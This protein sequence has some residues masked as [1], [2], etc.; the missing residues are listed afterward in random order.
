[1]APRYVSNKDES[2]PLF[3]NKLLDKFTYMH[4]STPVV[5]YLPVVAY[6]LY[7]AIVNPALSG[8]GI[9]LLFLGGMFAWSL[10]EYLFHRYVFHYETKSDFGRYLHFLMHGIH[11]DYPNDSRRLVMAPAVSIPLALFFYG[12]FW[13]TLGPTVMLAFFS[14]FVFGYL[15]YDMIHYAT[16]HAPMKG[17]IG[18]WLKH[19][20]VRHHYQD[21]TLG[22]GV[23]SPLWDLIFRTMFPKKEPASSPTE[24]H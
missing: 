7:R 12:L 8:T 2:I 19:H 14:G 11:H 9:F 23:S 20:H 13:L 16:H 1:V 22:Y 24:A 17:R 3:E 10:T 4:P 5:L 15:C 6:F 21:E 18:L